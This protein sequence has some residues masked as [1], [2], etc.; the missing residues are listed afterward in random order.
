MD[1][2][3][4]VDLKGQ[5]LKI[6]G[7][8]DS[9]LLQAVEQSAYI[10]GAQVRSFAD[11]LKSFCRADYAV[12]CANGTDA[13]QIAMMALGFKPGDEVIVPT[14]NYVSS[15]EVIV[16]LGLVP[17]FIDVWEDTFN[18][19]DQ[20]LEA[21][22]SQK[23]VGIVVTHL[24][25]Q[26][27]NMDAIM[28]IARHY[29]LK[30]IEDTAQALGAEYVSEDGKKMFAGTIADIGTTSF[31]PSKNLGCF[32]DGGA[33]FTN[34]EMLAQRIYMIANHGQKRKFQFE[35]I[36]INSRLD[37]IQAAVLNVKIKYLNEYT[38]SRQEVAAKYD[39]LGNVDGL[40]L[41]ARVHYSSHVFNQYTCR[42]LDGKRDELKAY[43]MEK[44]IPSMIYYPLPM[45]LQGAYIKHNDTGRAFPVAEKLGKDVLS[46]PIHTELT[47]KEL[48]Y[49][50][51]HIKTFL[52][53]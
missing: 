31:F 11:S 13:L 38:A 2:I 47:M 1:N 40:I 12:T 41:P 23:T 6:R 53:R 44:G 10:N 24:Y 45:H 51:A 15:V 9:A 21:A 20:Q 17:R 14:F 35:Y 43:L 52:K 39:E 18:I 5:Y 49:I 26:C 46:L 28:K 4:M 8:I 25:G 3:Q 7:E 48:E 29:K 16:L 33:I 34:D 42:I 27:C 32:G 36:G 22:I 50:I 19:D 30:V 37:T